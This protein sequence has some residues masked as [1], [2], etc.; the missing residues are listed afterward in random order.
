[1]HRSRTMQLSRTKKKK[2]LQ[3]DVSLRLGLP[4]LKT[5]LNLLRIAI[6]AFMYTLVRNFRY[7]FY[8]VAIFVESIESLVNAVYFL[9][10][11]HI[12]PLLS[13]NHLDMTH[14]LHDHLHPRQLSILTVIIGS[15]STVWVPLTLNIGIYLKV[16]F[17]HGMIQYESAMKK[18]SI[19]CITC[20]LVL[21]RVLRK[22]NFFVCST[23]TYY[24][25]SDKHAIIHND[26]L[27][28]SDE[29]EESSLTAKKH[30]KNRKGKKQAKS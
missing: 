10:E 26:R 16:F 19:F 12:K 21:M 27:Q 23:Q 28:V 6:W 24:F 15:L 4:S 18:R 8:I 29:Q 5:V 1:M 22:G 2:S 3:Q 13:L 7:K 14:R 9:K 30:K 25:A 17:V 11:Q 20:Y